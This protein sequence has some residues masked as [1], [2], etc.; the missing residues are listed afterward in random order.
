[1]FIAYLEES[2][3]SNACRKSAAML[4]SKKSVKIF[5][6]LRTGNIVKH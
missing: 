4:K 1:M 5:L 3:E 2:K 6:V